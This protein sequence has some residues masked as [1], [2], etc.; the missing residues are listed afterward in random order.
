MPY[1]TVRQT[2]RSQ[3]ITFEDILF[4]RV[5]FKDNDVRVSN[6]GT[7]TFLVERQQTID[8]HR[9]L[10]NVQDLIRTLNAFNSAFASVIDVEDKNAL[11]RT[12]HIPKKSGGYRQIN[13]PSTE[14]MGALRTLVSIFEEKFNA[15]YHT[16]AFAY[17]KGR[18]TIDAVKRHQANQSRWFLK[19]DFSDFFGSTTPE[20]LYDMLSRIF[21][22]SD[23]VQSGAGAD[24]LRKALSV[25]FLNGG[26]PQGSPASPM[27]TNLMMVPI[28][29]QLCNELLK[30]GYIYTRYADDILISSRGTFD[31]QKM[32]E[33][34]ES[35][36]AKFGAPF[37]I[38]PQKTRYGS[39]AGRNWNLGVMLNSQNEIT[40]GRKN[41]EY[42]KA[43]C[44]SY[45]NDKQHNTP[46]DYHDI[47]VLLGKI[48]YYRM[49]EPEYIKGF[50]EHFNQKKGVN[51]MRMLRDDIR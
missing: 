19:T 41:K 27:L 42:L 11:Y 17:V 18:C 48:S 49:V 35:V 6:G 25:C 7:V 44:N 29:H 37:R 33:Y 12:F 24:A 22:F 2:P 36:L 30:Q 20:F 16:S 23:V 13:E 43:A 28:D 46:W 45:V 4:G 5:P 26:L 50:I 47:N 10:V 51:L 8:Q 38:K 34:I 31:Y 21:P 15:L 14:L 1:I 3:Q 39:S 40:I 9:R 32:C